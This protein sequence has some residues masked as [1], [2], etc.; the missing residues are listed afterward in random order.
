M[1]PKLCRYKKGIRIGDE[2]HN[3]YADNVLLYI[4]N[5]KITLPNLMTFLKNHG[6][7]LHLKIKVGKI[8]DFE[9]K[10]LVNKKNRS[11]NKNFHL[12]EKQN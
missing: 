3:A 4:S 2:E 8:R 10:M 5:P 9:H 7:I 12:H 6:E 11:E 1:I